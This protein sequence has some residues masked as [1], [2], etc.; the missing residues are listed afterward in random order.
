MKFTIANKINIPGTQDPVTT[1]E[2]MCIRNAACQLSNLKGLGSDAEVLSESING[3]ILEREMAV[4]P[5]SDSVPGAIKL[6]LGADALDYVEKL[7]YDFSTHTGTIRNT[8]LNSSMASK[9]NSSAGVSIR[10]GAPFA[11][12]TVVHNI[13]VN[14]K[15]NMWFVGGQVEKSIKSELEARSPDIKRLTEE[16]LNKNIETTPVADRNAA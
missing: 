8:M 14:L 2:N 7:R 12:R 15:V 10:S 4:H 16:Y 1:Y 13:D 11:P 6:L 9:I 3:N 5:S